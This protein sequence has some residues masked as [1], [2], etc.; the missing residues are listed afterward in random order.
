[1]IK[2]F[3]GPC[4]EREAP[5]QGDSL[6]RRQIPEPGTIFRLGERASY[7][8]DLSFVAHRALPVGSRNQLK[9][10]VF[11]GFGVKE[12]PQDSEIFYPLLRL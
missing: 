6:G 10:N 8:E 4:L 7:D 3:E 11:L 2:A 12:A 5:D 1:M 9:S